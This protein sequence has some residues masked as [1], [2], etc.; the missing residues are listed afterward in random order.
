MSDST[1]IPAHQSQPDVHEDLQDVARQVHQELGDRR[2]P[3]Q[4]DE[5]LNRVA[6]RFDKAT[7][8]SFVP[9]LVRRYVRE[10]LTASLPQT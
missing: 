7:I 3:R 8:R 5:C 10:E 1:A 4:V 2:A 9:L 6:I